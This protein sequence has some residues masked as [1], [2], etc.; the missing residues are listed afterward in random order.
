MDRQQVAPGDAE[1]PPTAPPPTQ[2]RLDHYREHHRQAFERHR[3]TV[4]YRVPIEMQ[5]AQMLQQ[6]YLQPGGGAQK[7]PPT[8][9]GRGGAADKSQGVGGVE[10]ETS[11][12]G[13]PAE[14]GMVSGEVWSGKVFAA[15]PPGSTNA[16]L[17][18][19]VYL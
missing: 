8:T 10:L 14:E 2:G 15:R 11:E 19:T 3:H 4:S 5:Q 7:G 12:H 9:A 1:L 18:A 16:A 6:R 17:L 13:R